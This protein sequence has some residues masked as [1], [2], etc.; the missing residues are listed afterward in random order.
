M[1]RAFPVRFD[2]VATT[3]RNKPLLVTVETDDGIE[4]E[5]YVKA[6]AR[7]ELGIEGLANE[8]LAACL[9]ADLGL[10]IT[11]PFLVELDPQWVATIP[12]RETRAM[13]EAS[14]PLGFGS[15]AAGPQW[16]VWSRGDKML[17]VRSAMA[18]R[19]F[20]FDT[21][22]ENDD[23]K[24]SN[25]NCLLKG[26]EIRIIDHELAFR[27]RM[28]L[29]PKPEP[30]KLGGLQRHISHDGHLFGLA[31]KGLGLDFSNVK[32][33]WSNLSDSHIMG[34]CSGMP[35]EWS[36]ATEAVYAAVQHVRMVRDRLDDC[37]A[38]MQRV[39]T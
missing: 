3:G 22:I 11:E 8:A 23:R 16:K 18:L 37:L 5:A 4:H 9:A 35:T 27:I 1:R 32:S 21:F 20:A 33:T 28:K 29:F 26:D 13:L 6:S 30:W 17:S 36:A 25:P 15:K 39:L 19:I 10:P 2:R 14:V 7:P 12:D 34:Y 38:E 31:L 24:P